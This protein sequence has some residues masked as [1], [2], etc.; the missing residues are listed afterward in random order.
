MF[1]KKICVLFWHEKLKILETSVSRMW[2]VGFLCKN[3]TSSVSQA[4][5]A[6]RSCHIQCRDAS[7]YWERTR[8]GTNTW[9]GPD[10]SGNRCVKNPTWDIQP[11]RVSRAWYQGEAFNPYLMYYFL[12]DHKFF[13]VSKFW[14]YLPDR[15]LGYLST[16][17]L[18]ENLKILMRV[19]PITTG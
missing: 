18:K 8:G 10:T 11:N 3:H 14:K 5:L 17:S 4:R 12:Y 7:K 1:S 15:S 9:S 13:V 19:W 16:Y 6:P 2:E